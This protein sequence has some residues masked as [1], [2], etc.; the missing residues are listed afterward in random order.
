VGGASLVELIKYCITQNNAA[1]MARPNTMPA[2]TRKML[3]N[4]LMTRV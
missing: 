4:P 2:I 3:P 1:A